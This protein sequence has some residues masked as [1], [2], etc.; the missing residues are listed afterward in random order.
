MHNN[1]TEIVYRATSNPPPRPNTT[2]A[3]RILPT[4]RE[5]LAKPSP[6][7]PNAFRRLLHHYPI[8]QFPELLANIITYGARVGF[9]GAYHQPSRAR[10]HTSATQAPEIISRDIETELQL[11]RL[12]EL[13]TLPPQHFCSPLGLVPKVTNGVQTGWRRIFDLSYPQGESVNDGIPSQYGQLSY[14]TF[15]AALHT[16]A[17]LGPGTRMMK[18]DL[19]SAFR[20]IPICREDHLFFVFE[21]QGRYYIDLFLPF[22]LRTAP[23]IFNLFAEAL[24]WILQQKYGWILNHYLDD[25]LIF[26]PP[27]E[28]IPRASAQF[29]DICNYLGF[30]VANDKDAQGTTVDYLGLTIDSIKMEARL[31]INKLQR[32]LR[33]VKEILSPKKMITRHE[34]QSLLGF[35]TFCTKVFPLG[36][37]FLRHIFNMLR[38]PH[39]RQRLTAAARRD[40]QWWR[41][42]LPLWSGITAIS[43]RRFEVTIETDASGSKG[44]G[45][46]WPATKRMFSTRL[47]RRH[48]KKHINFKEMFAVLFAIAEWGESW[49]GQELLVKCD[50]EAVVHGINKKTIRGAAIAPLQQL[51]LLTALNDIVVKATWISTKENAVADALSRF[52]TKK[53]AKLVG[54]Q[55]LSMVQSRQTSRLSLKIS[56]LKRNTSSTTALRRPLDQPKTTRCANTKNTA[57]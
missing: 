31:P 47:P 57:C 27:N 46:Y 49:K 25:F 6:L 48:R 19:K 28:N 33:E 14:E 53:L 24:H 9:E 11:G 52:D 21:W 5:K 42:L 32:I 35:L 55:A 34:L 29:Q 18:R 26:F 54:V 4:N 56:H 3:F 2:P 15:D 23:F 17:R 16:I 44:I 39:K 37:P 22:G 7:N 20:V 51:L 12:L 43:P 36:R 1:H 30:Q 45:G 8:R 10:N 40:L 38:R 50:N 41:T 13:N